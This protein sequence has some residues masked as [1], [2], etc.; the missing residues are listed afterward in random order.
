MDLV[1]FSPEHLRGAGTDPERFVSLLESLNMD[2]L[3]IGPT[4][5]LQPFS[6]SERYLGKVGSGY[7]DLV[8]LKRPRPHMARSTGA[9]R[10][11]TRAHL[12]VD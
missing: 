5:R 7:G 9:S 10:W 3:E 11:P 4:G 8:L 1:E 2:I 6:G 12:N